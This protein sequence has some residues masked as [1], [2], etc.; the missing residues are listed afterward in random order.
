MTLLAEKGAAITVCYVTS[1]DRLLGESSQTVT[2]ERITEARMVSQFLGCR[3]SL[4][5]GFPDGDVRGHA[6]AITSELSKVI[7]GMQPDLMLAPSPIDFHSDHL[8]LAD[9]ALKLRQGHKGL[10]LAFYEVYTTMRFNCLVDIT[11]VI[12]K[13]KEA[14]SLYR[15][16]LYGKPEVYVHAA[17][18]LNAHRS[19]FTVKEGYFE[20]FYVVP[21]DASPDAALDYL[22]YRS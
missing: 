18:G 11:G 15:K 8:A 7:T 1:G 19:L 10:S 22:T 9:I 4:F 16:S 5:L 14:I 17:L 2:D 6:A 21:Q 20:A 13:K 12:G 3:E